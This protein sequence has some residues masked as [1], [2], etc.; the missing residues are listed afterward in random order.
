MF[1]KNLS[2]KSEKADLIVSVQEIVMKIS[3]T[4]DNFRQNHFISKSQANYTTKLKRNS[5]QPKR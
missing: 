5:S 1:N 4:F 2:A 3:N